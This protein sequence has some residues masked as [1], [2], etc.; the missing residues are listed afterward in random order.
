LSELIV[1]I[2]GQRFEARFERI[3]APKT[4]AAFERQLP[5]RQS[6]IHVR[7]SGE[8]M[9]VP[10]GDFDFGLTPESATCYPAPGQMLLYPGGVS[11]TE[12]IL[13]YGPTRFASKAGQLAGNPLLTLVSDLGTLADIGREVLWKG[14]RKIEIEIA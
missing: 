1:T 7:W 2:A 3:L 14:A 11:E 12:L 8:A 13:A 10:L 4:V 6:L 5:F 9:W